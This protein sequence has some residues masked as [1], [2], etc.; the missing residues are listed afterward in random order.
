MITDTSTV[1]TS[2]VVIVTSIPQLLQLLLLLLLLLLVPSFPTS[3]VAGGTTTIRSALYK[4]IQNRPN[5]AQILSRP[6]HHDPLGLMHL[7]YGNHHPFRRQQRRRR[8]HLQYNE[9]DLEYD[10]H[11]YDTARDDDEATPNNNNNID[12]YSILRVRFIV[13]PLLSK[14]GREFDTAIDYIVHEILPAVYETWARHL[15]VFPVQGSIPISDHDCFGGFLQDDLIPQSILQNG[16]ADADLVILVHGDDSMTF[17]DG[18][19]VNFC[20]GNNNLAVATACTLDQY[21]RPVIGFI[22]FCLGNLEEEGSPVTPFLGTT[23]VHQTFLLFFFVFVLCLH[24]Y[25][26]HYS[27]WYTLINSSTFLCI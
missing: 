3:V 5:V 16:V 15:S 4:H 14:K 9:T 10:Y 13:E 20:S 2:L 7:D 23:H 18:T 19:M 25:W 27:N 24:S 6:T 26:M 11:D 17:S 12:D 22:N 21:D 1:P 8:R